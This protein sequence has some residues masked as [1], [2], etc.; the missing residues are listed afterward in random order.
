MAPAA[1][2]RFSSARRARPA[3]TAA[4]SCLSWSVCRGFRH[5]KPLFFRS[6]TLRCPAS[7]VCPVSAR[8]AAW[9]RAKVTGGSSS[10][11]WRTRRSALATAASPLTA[12]RPALGLARRPAT[13][14][15]AKR[16]QRLLAQ[17]NIAKDVADMN[18]RLH[19]IDAL[20]RQIVVVPD[21]ADASDL[22]DARDQAVNEL[23]ELL[24]VRTLERASGELA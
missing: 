3:A 2:W 10:W 13:P 8:N 15:R 1:A 5:E 22:L 18:G 24:P 16:I 23:M 6:T 21:N 17:R 19:A 11:R 14:L 12:G 7:I 9:I 20:I 4:R